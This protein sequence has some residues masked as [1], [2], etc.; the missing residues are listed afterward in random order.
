MDIRARQE[1]E[2][3]VFLGL[4]KLMV[5]ADEVLSEEETESIGKL[6]QTIGPEAWSKAAEAAGPR[7]PSRASVYTAAEHIQREEVHQW[8]YRQL[9]QLGAS[10]GLV[11]EEREILT[12]LST[13]WK[14]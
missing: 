11:A 6:V 3:I 12:T 10:D 7:F 4:L 8:M 1:E 5:H 9:F 14:I 13:L 2:L